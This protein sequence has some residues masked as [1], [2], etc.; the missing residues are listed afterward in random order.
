MRGCCGIGSSDWPTSS[1]RQPAVDVPKIRLEKLEQ[2]LAALVLV[3][4]ADV[5]RKSSVDA[6]LLPEPIRLRVVRHLRPD[7]D[8]DPGHVVIARDRLNH[9]LLFGR[10]VH[11]R[12]HASKE[13]LK[14]PKAD[15]RI[16]LGGRHEDRPRGRGPRAVIRLVVPVAEE[17]AEVVRPG[18]RG[19]VLH[20]RRARRSLGVEPSKL[21]VERMLAVRT[22]PPIAG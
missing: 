2:L 9:R 14:Q 22:P 8:D 19:D 4:A 10:V 1:E 20:E 3:D 11:Q 15:R 13:R 16:A 18:V 17:Q 5:D 7:A 12:A 6:V 21:V